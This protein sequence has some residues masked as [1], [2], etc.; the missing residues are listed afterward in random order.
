MVAPPARLTVSAP[1]VTLSCVVDR[2][3]S[4]SLTLTP[5]IASTV[6]SFTLC[7]PGTV[8]SGTSFTGLTV[9][10]TVSASVAPFPSVDSTVSVSAPL[11]STLPW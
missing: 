6:S 2:L 10:A 8:F 1:L 7:A 4:T 5:L 9:I 3:P 11:K